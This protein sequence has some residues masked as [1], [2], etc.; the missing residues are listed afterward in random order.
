M[1]H[2]VVYEGFSTFSGYPIA[3]K[4][5]TLK[6]LMQNRCFQSTINLYNKILE[7]DAEVYAKA[8]RLTIKPEIHEFAFTGNIVWSD[9]EHL[10]PEMEFQGWAKQ[11]N[12]HIMRNPPAYIAL[13]RLKEDQKILC[14]INREGKIIENGRTF[15]I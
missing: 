9:T 13:F 1:L 5:P 15:K 8:H 12:G 2:Y 7:E 11:Y 3:L 14:S 4:E 6:C 10:S